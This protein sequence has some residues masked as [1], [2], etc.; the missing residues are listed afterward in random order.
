VVTSFYDKF[1]SVL[2]CC[3][4]INNLKYKFLAPSANAPKLHILEAFDS[5]TVEFCLTIPR[6]AG[7]K[8]KLENVEE[9]IKLIL[10]NT[11]NQVLDA[12]C[13]FMTITEDRRHSGHYKRRT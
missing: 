3:S 6:S 12:F 7:R 2:E 9:H 5:F 1:I 13:T 8:N 10:T 4:L 11:T